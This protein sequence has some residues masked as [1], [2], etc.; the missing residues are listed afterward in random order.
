MSN[1]KKKII[2]LVIGASIV[3]IIIGIFILVYFFFIKDLIGK[4]KNNSGGSDDGSKGEDPFAVIVPQYKEDNEKLESEFEFKT[5]VGDLRRI[6]V[7]QRYDEDRLYEGEKI[8]R[9]KIRNTTYDIFIISESNPEE[10]FINY[11]NKRYNS[12]ISIVSECFASEDE[13]CIP[14][15]LVDLSGTEVHNTRNLEEKNDLKDIPI[16]LCLF[17]LTNNDVITSIKCP[18]SFS[19][20]KKKLIV[21]DLYFFRPPGLKRMNKEE[22][23]VTITKELKGEN[24][25]IRETNGGICD[26]EN[27][28][29]SFCTTDM[30]TTT[31]KE[32]RILSYEEEAYMNI[33]TDELNSYTKIKITK[34]VDITN[35][36]SLLDAKKYNSSLNELLTKLEPYM[37]YEELF[38]KDEFEEILLINKEG[39]KK[40]KKILKRIKGRKLIEDK[41]EGL[42]ENTLV[43]IKGSSGI[44]IEYNIMNNPGK[45][46]EYMEANSELKIENQKRQLTSSQESSSSVYKIINTLVILSQAGNNLAAKLLQNLNSTLVNMTDFINDE[47]TSLYSLIKYK[48]ISDIFDATLSMD[49]INR[50]PFPII[51]ESSNL[52]NKLEQLLNSIE[53]GAIKKNIKI[54]NTNIYDYTKE[55]HQ[56]I[57]EL[58]DNLSELGKALNSEKS[59]L[60]E[61]STYYL[62][63]TNNSYLSNI[64][65]AEKILMNYYKDEYNLINPEVEKVLKVFE[66][67]ITNSLQKQ[68][69]IINNLYEKIENG[70]Y[71]IEDAN[72]EEVK[73]IKNNLYYLKNY[74]NE[75]ITKIETKVKN[76]MEIKDNG[77]L[78][79]DYDI[80]SNMER[81][82]NVITNAKEIAKKLDN[83]S[84]IDKKFDEIMSNFRQNYTNIQKFMDK[85]QK[86]KFPLN[87]QVLRTEHFSGDVLNKME[88]D[89][90]QNGVSI[91][92]GIRKENEEYLKEKDR[93]INEFITNEQDYLNK[94]TFEID[95]Q[96]TEKKLGELAQLYDAAY[97]SCIT[98]TR[99]ELNNNKNSASNYFSNMV[100]YFNNNN[101]LLQLLRQYKSDEATLLK[102]NPWATLREYKFEDTINTKYRTDLHSSKYEAFIESFASSK[103]FINNEIYE[104]LLNEYKNVIFKLRETLQ[105]FKN[106]K[107]TTQYP[108]TSEF[109]FIDNH[110]HTI[111]TLYSRLNNKI[112]DNIFNNNYIKIY[113]DLRIEANNNINNIVLSV[114]QNNN[115]IKSKPYTKNI[116]YDFCLTYNRKITYT[117]IN[118]VDSV[119]E[120][121]D[122]FC[123]PVNSQIVRHSIYTDSNYIKFKNSFNDFYI[124]INDRVNKYSA[125]I[126]N[127]KNSLLK[128]EKFAINKNYTLNYLNP[129]QNDIN[130]LLNEKYGEKLIKSSYNYYQDNI[131][132]L[133]EPLLNSISDKWIES[134]DILIQEINENIDNFKNSKSEFYY[135]AATY[136]V[137]IKNNMTKNYY[138]SIVTH[139]KNEFN[140]TITYYY[141]VLLKLV[142][143][144]HQYI[145]N[146]IPNNRVGYN[147]I[148]N[149]RK[150]EVNNVFFN[151][152]HIIKKS[153][154]NSLDAD[155]QINIL[156]VPKTNFFKINEVLSNNILETDNAFQPKFF[157]IFGIKF[158]KFNDEFSLSARFYL[159]NQHS[160]IQ[161]DELYD[162]INRKIFIILNLEQFKD[163]LIE[164]WIF[165][166]TNL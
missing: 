137:I 89:I 77:Y 74:M 9:K 165:D 149:I 19:E 133:M 118:G 148:L 36:T 135:M 117:C 147:N 138:N 110:I 91:L 105:N 114:N 27:P 163:I 64:E 108:D 120:E 123:F 95:S 86:E 61:I 111:D 81:S 52:K 13:D 5:L 106:N 87:E 67:S 104:V 145:I 144:T 47:I 152:I 59:K 10:D 56:I 28:L 75:I 46:N 7:L 121:S 126:A 161:I 134:F 53:N 143:A 83:D 90:N 58:F 94:L 38:S 35:E 136:S 139:Q 109:F 24:L 18:E 151:L 146:K 127:L 15:T 124:S 20:D 65:T 63:N 37:K 142:N 164:N 102:H 16:P 122:K 158:S 12:A 107:M 98:K 119:H 43:D 92:N 4:K 22:L 113:D 49:S 159:E 84:F 2:K 97:K 160:K 14:E 69:I 54:L 76:E 100:S 85:E 26:I 51:L 141:N 140:Y 162:Q 11:Y 71:S 112:S 3:V 73:V 42:I 99:N 41:P 132:S 96:F 103:E 157:D 79:T 1:Q 156:Q 131:E 155:K 68:I 93:I 44:K 6:Q 23:N 115:I 39:I 32:G 60:T 78:L 30:N 45:D 17:N 21:L 55:S 128:A 8:Q 153:K 62:N 66:D 88:R 50:L 25:F 125:K 31:D 130:S 29:S 34:L 154:D 57:N 150:N 82:I 80:N 129:I 116:I 166:K 40:A 70:N 33:E 48:D 72:V 101:A